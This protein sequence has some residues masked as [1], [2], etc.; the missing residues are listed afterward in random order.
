M[1]GVERESIRHALGCV[2]LV[3]TKQEQ[4]EWRMLR[5]PVTHPDAMRLIVE[6]SSLYVACDDCGHSRVLRLGN[7]RAVSELGVHNYMQLCRKIRCSECPSLPL[8]DRN[9]T[10]IPTWCEPIQT[11]A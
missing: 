4:K 10:I 9:L 2:L 7:L 3:R 6:L 11:M 5:P 1:C 8:C